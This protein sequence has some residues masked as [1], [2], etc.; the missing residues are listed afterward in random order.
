MAE[1]TQTDLMAGRQVL[2]PEK[3]RFVRYRREGEVVWLTLDR[4][5]NNLLN[6]P[7]LQELAK[8]LEHSGNASDVKV[9]VLDSACSVFSGGIDLGEYTQN[10]V[11]QVLSAF[12]AA[13]LA[14]M[15]ASKPL[16]V[17]VNGPAVGGG[18]EL[19]AM[20]DLVIA[21]PR[22]KFAQPEVTIG[23]FPP[24]AATVLPHL[25][26]PKQ[27]L[28]MVLIGEP[29]SA[30]RALE[31]GLVNRVV[32]EAKLE[33][34]VNAL[35]AQIAAQSGPVLSMAKRAVL[36]GMGLSL[37]DSLH[38][39]IQIFLNELYGLEDSQEGLRAVLEKRKPQWKNR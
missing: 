31:L 33:A 9:M 10:R 34:T 24:L 8:A 37:K 5:E 4:P 19:A 32:P 3:F 16:I 26:G 25:I 15:E 35:V 21:T 13:F 36:G 20:G 38:K 17:V 27:T 6:E 29:I 11:F 14:M 2:E 12:E 1:E 39:S 7:M 18:S 28:E 22:A 30:E 23:V